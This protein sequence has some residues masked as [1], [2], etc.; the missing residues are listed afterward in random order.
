MTEDGRSI[1]ILSIMDEYSRFCLALEVRRS[2]TAKEVSKVLKKAIGPFGTP[3]FI[4]SDNDGPELVAKAMQT[5]LRSRKVST[6]YIEPGSP[7]QNPFVES[8]HSRFSDECLNREWFINLP[9]AKACIEEFRKTYNTDRPHS[10]I[11]Y[12]CPI[13]I[14]FPQAFD[15]GRATP[16]PPSKT[17]Q[18]HPTNANVNL[19]PTG[20]THHLVHFWGPGQMSISTFAKD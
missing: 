2:F 6:V 11:E 17:C 19:N 13:E 3:D 18:P 16:L 12:K 4:R 15:S 9:D 10:G 1:R 5:W 14:Y 20:L 7:W 8:F